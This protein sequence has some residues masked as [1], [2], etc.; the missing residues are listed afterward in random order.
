GQPEPYT[1]RDA[2][3]ADLPQIM[4]LY[5]RER[6]RGPVAA[7][8]DQAYWRWN[9]AGQNPEAAD[10]WRIFMIVDGAGRAVGYLLRARR[11]WG[12]AV[13]VAAMWVEPGV[14]L[15]V[16]LPPTLRALQAQA[17]DMPTFLRTDTPPPSRIMFGLERAHPVYDALDATLAATTRPPYGWYVRVPD[18][19]CFIRQIAPALERRLAASP[20]VAGYSGELRLDFYRGGLRL[21]FEGGRLAAAEDWK[22]R[23]LPWGPK[24]QAGFPP[25]VFLQLL[26]GRRSL[27]E[28]RYAFPDVWAEDEGGPLLEALFPA[29]PSWV[30]P[31]D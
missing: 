4:A 11:R 9:L 27:E 6:A 17:A 2:T 21:A 26:F 12:E 7:R 19:P 29:R 13:R 10:G 3:L 24:A 5:D 16:V 8:V 25:L 14:P 20:V 23:A 18:L 31:L 28:L 22:A 1:L 30:L 15:A